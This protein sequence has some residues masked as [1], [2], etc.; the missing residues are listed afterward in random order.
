MATIYIVDDEQSIRETLRSAFSDL[1]H[2][3]SVFGGGAEALSTFQAKPADLII[4][5]VRMPGMDGFS[6]LT[7]IKNIDPGVRFIV[8]TAYGSI[9]AAVEAMKLGALDYITKPFDLVEIEAKVNRLF[10]P[11]FP[12]APAAAGCPLSVYDGFIS[13]NRDM[14]LAYEVAAKA[15]RNRSNVL[16]RGDSG[17]G[18]ELIARAIHFNGPDA[19][20]RPFVKI[21]C[22]ALAPGVLE[23]ELF[24]HEKGSFTGAMNQRKGKFEIADNGT[25]FLDEIGDVPLSTQVKLLRVLQEKEFERVGGNETVRV[26]VRIIS[27]TNR[28]LE[29]MIT[30][31]QFREDLYYRLNVIPILVT[32]LR[33]RPEDIPALVDHF[34]ARNKE[35]NPVEVTGCNEKL[36]DM[37]CAYPWP[38]NI[39]ELENLIERMVVLSNEAI[40]NEA[41]LPYEIKSRIG[42]GLSDKERTFSEQA[43]GYEKRLIQQALEKHDTC[44]VAAA[45]ELK[46]D[47][48][49]LRYKMKKYGLL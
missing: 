11:V 5:D 7:A 31:S 4:S 16:I 37:L 6:L 3:V 32:P 9:D 25:L 33:E 43:A 28:N 20:K 36:L 47:R 38:G 8:M 46:M 2:Q 48:S 30:Q 44:Q 10:Q 14:V 23:S 34:I 39:R 41:S 21:N 24:G 12:P 27:A 19:D 15:S 29:E 45:K 13:R 22:A 1:G 18:K 26:D 40:L 35:A 42:S 17:T 49:T